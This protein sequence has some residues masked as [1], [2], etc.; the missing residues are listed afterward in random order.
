LEKSN[1]LPESWETVSLSEIATINPPKPEKDSVSDDLQV[2][3]VPMKCVEEL[4]GKVDLSNTRKY[5]HVKKGY[6]YFRDDDIIFAKI[7][8]C[9]E[10]GKIAIAQGLKNGI[11]FGS[12]EFHV[13]RLKDSE[14][15]NKFY[16]WYLMQEDFRNKAQREMKG[17][18][19]HLRVPPNY[20]KDVIIP[21]PP[22]NEQKRIVAK[23]EELFS[24]MEK[25]YNLLESSKHLIKNYKNSLLSEAFNEKFDEV[26]INEIS[27]SIRDGTHNPPKRVSKGISLLSARNIKNGFIDWDEKYSKISE[28]D[29]HEITRNNSIDK[30]DILLTIVGTLGRSCVVNTKLKFTVQRSV[31]IIKLNETVIPD[32][33]QLYFESPIFQRALK[34][35][36]RGIAQVGV[37]LNLLKKLDF[38]LPVLEQQKS[39][40][41]NL[42]K[43]I[44]LIENYNGISESL[45]KQLSNL[46]QALQKQAFEGKLVP[47]DPNDEPAS[48]LLK[49]IK[50]KMTLKKI[51]TSR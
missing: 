29:F 27:T 19:G 21:I 23:I 5:K 26:S 48:E 38:P 50:S 36:S 2:S 4:T 10:N 25:T 18:V 40:V 47:Q 6:T 51:D 37:Y 30:N 43:R 45:F 35:N 16:F 44:S 33:V 39:I 24:L 49:R 3:F 28:K 11:A 9:M 20:M 7:T 42:K 1:G 31:A 8:P 22:L 14:I 17:T 46:K 34:K 32:F 13:I 12:T 41:N 15:S